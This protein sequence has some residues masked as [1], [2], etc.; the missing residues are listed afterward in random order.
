MEHAD[1]VEVGLKR[2]EH[3]FGRRLC[4]VNLLNGPWTAQVSLGV[5]P[6]GL[7]VSTVPMFLFESEP[8]DKEGMVGC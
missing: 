3:R 7:L 6:D 4:V 8:I 1:T 5:V 2:A